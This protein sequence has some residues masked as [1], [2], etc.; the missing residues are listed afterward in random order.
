MSS[1]LSAVCAAMSVRDL[2]KEL[3]ERGVNTAS[4]IEKADLVRLLVTNWGMEAR[5]QPQPAGVDGSAAGASF[6]HAHI[7]KA[8]F[9]CQACG[10]EH[11]Q[12]G[13]VAGGKLMKCSP[14][15]MGHTTAA[16]RARWQTGLRTNHSA[17]R[18]K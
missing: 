10:E 8:K 17:T 9:S 2:Q 6:Q 5:P 18:S 1:D 12:H 11:G 7:R 16:R 14:G 4:C 13:N 15:A 3:R